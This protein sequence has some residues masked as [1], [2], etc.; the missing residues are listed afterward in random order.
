MNDLRRRFAAYTWESVTDGESGADVYRLEGRDSLYLKVA[1]TGPHTDSGLDLAAEVARGEW[2]AKQGIPV[3][4]IL[5]HAVDATGGW[6][7]T[8]AVPGRS[9]ADPWP[10]DQRAAVVDAVADA[11]RALHEL[12]LDTCPFD[13]SLAVTIPIARH[14]VAADLVD[15]ADLDKHRLGRTAEDLLDELIATTPTTEDL[16]VGHGD[17]TLPNVLL[18]PETRRVIALIDLGRLG[19]VDRHADP[20]LVTRQLLDPEDEQYGP[21]YADR[22]LA[23]YDP[24]GDLDPD[25]IEFYRLLDEF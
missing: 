21:A 2:A 7:L 4:E 12:P 6:L 9:A 16:V 25:R 22:F 1:R 11:A 20:A 24:A 3:A 10:V 17:Y 5:D 23:R 18:D 15:L 19:R 8:R 13:R 14:A